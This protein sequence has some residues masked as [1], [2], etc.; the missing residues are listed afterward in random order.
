MANPLR[1]L[2][3]L[4]EKEILLEWY[5]NQNTT[6]KLLVN[7]HIHSPYSFSAFNSLQEAFEMAARQKIQV[8]GLNDFFVAD[9]YDEFWKLALKYSCFPLFNIEFIGLLQEE[10]KNNIRINDPNNPGRT[11]FSG[12]G[13]DYPFHQSFFKRRAVRKLRK[14]SQN[15][16]KQMIQKTDALLKALNPSLSLTYEDIRKEL[17]RELVRERHIAKALRILMHKHYTTQEQQSAFL[18]EL[19][20]GKASKVDPS[21]NAALENE[22]RGALLKSGGRAFVEENPDAFLPLDKIISI[23]RDAGGIPC[24]PVLLDDKNGTY[25]E[26]E[27]DAEKLC[28]SLQM[29]NVHCIELIPGRNDNSILEKFVRYFHS[30]DFIISFGTEHNAP[31]MIPLT[32]TARGKKELS[33]DVEAI[34]VEGACVVAAHQYLRAKGHQGYIYKCGT[35]AIDR[36]E[37]FASLGKAVINYFLVEGK[38]A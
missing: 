32:V 38:N 34:G 5:R 6:G 3:D 1:S 17:A 27:Q 16:V 37:E 8:L 12:K 29:M 15:Q 30:Q 11:Y 10:Q 20:G 4:P 23:I 25:T 26:F 13:L 2:A 33:A 14:E 35:W 9:G 7:N 36:K 19:Y 21:D 24:Y 18:T 28:K 31:D 22:L